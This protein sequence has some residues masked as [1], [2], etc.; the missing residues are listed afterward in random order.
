MWDAMRRLIKPDGPLEL[1]AQHLLSG[2]Q[3]AWLVF[4]VQRVP[5]AVARDH[6]INRVT[7]YLIVVN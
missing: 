1:I 2:Y 6:W 3:Y 5:R 7:Q 4:P